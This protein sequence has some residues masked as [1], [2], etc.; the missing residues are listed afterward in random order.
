MALHAEES[1]ERERDRRYWR[2]LKK[3]LEK[4]RRGG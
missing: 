3:E 1:N 2:P 4:L